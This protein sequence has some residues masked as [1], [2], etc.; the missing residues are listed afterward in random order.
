M[1]LTRARDRL[2]L[3]SAATPSGARGPLDPAR[4]RAAKR[5][6]DWLEA[7]LAAEGL[8]VAREVVRAQDVPL[9]P[10]PGG[11]ADFDISQAA[12]AFA[13][14]PDRRAERPEPPP[15]RLSASALAETGQGYG[16]I[17]RSR[18]QLRGGRSPAA[19]R[20]AGVYTHRL[21]ECIDLRE[22][23]EDLRSALDDLIG[24]GLLPKAAA[25]A[26]D[27]AAVQRFLG[28][29]TAARIKGAQRLEREL[30][31]SVLADAAGRPDPAGGTV[32]QGKI[33][34]LLEDDRGWLIVDF[35]TDHVAREQV[36][37]AAQAYRGQIDAYRQALLAI[38]GVEAQ[39]LL[40]FLVP[41][42]A[43]AVP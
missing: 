40:Y 32:L 3:T 6:L 8:P 20:A 41:G 12:A 27:L 37:A 36:T 39:G 18:R 10:A 16:A 31:F 29:P 25:R 1:A 9:A 2:Y 23:P 4:L 26:V 19:A 30:A 28:S 24:R 42:V 38:A 13:A 11:I 22:P 17:L 43:V 15:L 35:K 34:L 21:L 14:L 7:P 5:P 33:D